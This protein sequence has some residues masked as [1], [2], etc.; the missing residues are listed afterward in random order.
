M[1]S[2]YGGQSQQRWGDNTLTQGEYLRDFLLTDL[3]GRVCKTADARRK[4]MLLVVFFRPSDPISKQ[5]LQ[6]VQKIADA[7]RESGKLTVLAVS[8]ED[9]AATRAAAPSLGV[10]FPVL[11]DHDRYHAMLYGVTALPSLFLAGGD[12]RVI[13]KSAGLHGAAVNEISAKVA[14]FAGVAGVAI[15]PAAYMPETPAPPPP[16]AP[17]PAA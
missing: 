14:V 17:A 10:S 7:Y 5:A 13:R 11:V 2:A 16:P 12:G 1:P 3:S 4:G 8:E 9:E 15:D 6:Q